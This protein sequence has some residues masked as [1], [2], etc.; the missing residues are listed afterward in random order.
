MREKGSPMTIHPIDL[1]FQGVPGIIAAH[2]LESGGEVALIETGPASCQEALVAGLRSLGIGVKEVRKVLVTHI[3][4][5]HAGGAGW[6]AQQG[7]QVFVHGKGAPH[8]IDPAKL[9]DSATRIYGERMDALWGPIL[10]APPERVTVL[11]DGDRVRVGE[12]EI[13]AWNTP[14]HARHHHAFVTGD[15]CFTGDVAGVRL[16]GFE[17]LSVAAAPP[18]FDPG[19]YEASV[20]RLIAGGFSKLYLAHFG[21]VIDPAQHLQ[22]Y[23]QRIIDVHERIAGWKHEGL[24]SDEIARRYTQSEHAIAALPEAAWQRYEL[25]NGTVMC[26]GGIELYVTKAAESEA[27]NHAAGR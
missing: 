20:D 2:V 15:V 18:Q 6:W 8:V 5:D 12:F 17:Y 13:E 9:I 27:A 24:D 1:Q 3:H 7:A 10:P 26:A 25:A 21:E 14:G 23:R 22:R 19:A 4:L 11:E 16:Q